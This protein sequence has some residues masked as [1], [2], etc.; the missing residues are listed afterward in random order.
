MGPLHESL[1]NDCEEKA[2]NFKFDHLF[3]MTRCHVLS[4]ASNTGGGSK[5]Q[6]QQQQPKKTKKKQKK[7]SA[8][9]DIYFNRHEDEIFL[10]N[11]SWHHMF[12]L[13]PSK[14]SKD[15]I[16]QKGVFMVLPWAGF[17]QAVVALKHVEVDF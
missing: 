12:P 4:G 17:Q 2:K 6:Q 11:A 10:D 5:Q 15:T 1:K 3:L 9:D 8:E 7:A 14:D 16:P 13:P